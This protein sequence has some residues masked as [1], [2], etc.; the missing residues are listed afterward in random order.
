MESKRTVWEGGVGGERGAL[1][2]GGMDKW[3]RPW[4]RGV[5]G[6]SLVCHQWALCS[7]NVF[8]SPGLRVSR[9]KSVLEAQVRTGYRDLALPPFP[10]P[11]RMRGGVW[12]PGG[13]DADKLVT[14]VLG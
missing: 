5:D 10:S 8:S 7:H 3:G 13:R 11:P 12:G 9:H 2:P 1:T 4:E 6:A 14:G